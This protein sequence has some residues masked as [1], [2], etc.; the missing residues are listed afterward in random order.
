MTT[1]VLAIAMTI[2]V[3]LGAAAHAA[4]SP[5]SEL[6][7][8]WD[9]AMTTYDMMMCASQDTKAADADLNKAYRKLLASV[10]PEQKE[11]LVAAERAWITFRDADCAFVG[12]AGGTISIVD[13]VTCRGD[14]TIDRI[15]QLEEWPPNHGPED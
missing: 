4:P 11:K 2:A 12:S 15:K 13:E 3:T 7:K 10:T 5:K 9:T 6:P 8:C 14:R 1:R